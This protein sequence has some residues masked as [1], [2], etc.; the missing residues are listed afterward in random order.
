MFS[1]LIFPFSDDTA[2]NHFTTRMMKND[3]G[4][5]SAA[6]YQRWVEVILR[7]TDTLVAKKGKDTAEGA[8]M[9]EKGFDSA[10]KVLQNV[11]LL[12]I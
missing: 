11:R 7:L 3:I 6:V 4:K 2:V 1:Q 8:K 5:L 10:I 9:R 12:A